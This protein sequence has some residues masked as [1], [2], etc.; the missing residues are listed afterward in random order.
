MMTQARIAKIWLKTHHDLDGRKF[1]PRGYQTYP[2][3]LDWLREEFGYRC[4]YCGLRERCT[5]SSMAFAIEH[6]IPQSIDPDGKVKYE[7]LAYACAFCNAAKGKELLFFDPETDRIRKHIKLELSGRFSE[8][9]NTGGMH[10]DFLNLNKP[11]RVG[12]RRTIL[13]SAAALYRESGIDGLAEYFG[14]PEELPDLR[15]KRV[16]IDFGQEF[17]NCCSSVRRENAELPKL[18]W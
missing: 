3:F 17:V 12:F 15:R 11:R 6:I 1:R 5:E 13:L 4:A 8:L 7:N 2:S 14:Y 10:I 9:T 16:E 18:C